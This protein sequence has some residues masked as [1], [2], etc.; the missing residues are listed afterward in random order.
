[1]ADGLYRWQ[2]QAPAPD[3]ARIEAIDA[4]Y[5]EAQ[6][7]AFAEP[8]RAAAVERIERALAA[9]RTDSLSEAAFRLAH[10]RSALEGL[11]PEALEP[12]RGLAGLFD[13][14][15]G[16]LRRFREAYRLSA[17]AL[18]DV[19]GDLSER[20][21]GATRR[22]GVLDGVWAEVRDA[23]VDLDA[24]LLAAARRLP[25]SA[26]APAST[27][28]AAHPLEARKAALHASRAAAL[29][30]LPLIRGAQNADARAAEALRACGDGVAVWRQGWSEALGLAGKRPKKVRPDRERLL[31]LRDDLLARVD[32][33][34]AELTASRGRRD[35]VAARLADLRAPL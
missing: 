11:K 25:G 30:A 5:D 14:R 27:D 2:G 33:A 19:A 12:R 13:S 28:E 15:K 18:A 32:R 1:M 31:R 35:D 23:L 29:S 17:A 4:G 7:H 9:A 22:S 8:A 6:A 3:A 20:V 21:E 16:R 34:L 24:H 26:S 10:A